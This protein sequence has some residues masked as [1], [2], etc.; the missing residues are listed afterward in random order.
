MKELKN[1]MVLYHGSYCV[2]K[3]PDL[4][5]CAP[6]KD[7]GQGFYLTTSHEQARSFARISFKKVE[8]KG[9]VLHFGFAHVSL[10]KVNGVDSLRTF[11]YNFADEAWL[12]CIVAHRRNNIFEK[13][14]KKMQDYDVI[15]GKIAND[16]TNATITAYMGNVFGPMGSEQADRMCISLL[17]PEW[18]R[19]QFCF[20]SEAA[21]SALDFIGNERIAVN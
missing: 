21:I 11:S 8:L 2:V 15:F 13:V 16:D 19:D 18:L 4:E 17:L 1:G 14:K 7:F 10:F 9:L 6:Y 3:K 12:H 20:R 5:K